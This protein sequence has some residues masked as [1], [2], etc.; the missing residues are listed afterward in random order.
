MKTIQIKRKQQNKNENTWT[1]IMRN[2][3]KKETIPIQ[4]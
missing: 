4:L 3:K 1:H 2:T